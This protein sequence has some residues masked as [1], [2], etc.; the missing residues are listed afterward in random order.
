MAVQAG[1][2]AGGRVGR[3][4]SRPVCVHARCVTV[5]ASDAV[6][7]S[8]CCV[9]SVEVGKVLHHLR[10]RIEQQ[11]KFECSSLRRA[12]VG[13]DFLPPAD[14]AA[15]GTME[16][17]RQHTGTRNEYSNNSDSSSSCTEAKAALPGGS[18][19]PALLGPALRPPPNPP[20]AQQLV[21]V[22]G[23]VSVQAL[24][25]ANHLVAKGEACRGI[26]EGEGARGGVLAKEGVGWEVRELLG[27]VI[28][29]GQQQAVP[30]QSH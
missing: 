24:V 23:K 11:L 3:S 28:Q 27:L 22:A 29:Q 8:P 9:R 21:E 7:P 1:G 17:A 6:L 19:I 10:S 25:A 4:V 12:A 30:H 15:E 26:P 16:A 5:H 20:V 14:S 18:N 13:C 2:Q